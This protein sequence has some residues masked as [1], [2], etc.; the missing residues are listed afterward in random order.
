M[1]LFSGSRVGVLGSLG[2]AGAGVGAGVRVRTGILWVFVPGE[3]W[4]PPHLLAVDAVEG[5]TLC[6]R[7]VVLPV[8]ADPWRGGRDAR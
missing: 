5:F 1:R 6:H 3:G 7:E 2:W 8:S 4:H